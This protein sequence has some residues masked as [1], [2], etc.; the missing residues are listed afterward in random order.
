MS[1]DGVLGGPGDDR[2]T[3]GHPTSPILNVDPGQPESFST[4]RE[5]PRRVHAR[6]LPGHPAYEQGARSSSHGMADPDL[7]RRQLLQD[8]EQ[9]PASAVQPMPPPAPPPYYGPPPPGYPPQANGFATPPVNY[10]PPP[11]QALYP[12]PG[13][14]Q[15]R[16]VVLAHRQADYYQGQAQAPRP[17]DQ[18]LTFRLSEG[19]LDVY[20]HRVVRS[21]PLLWLIYDARLPGQRFLP[22]P[23]RGGE[24]R[25]FAAYVYGAERG[26]LLRATHCRLR[27][28]QYDCV[29]LEILREEASAQERER[30]HFEDQTPALPEE[31]YGGEAGGDPRG[32]D[33]AGAAGVPDFGLDG[34]P[35]EVGPG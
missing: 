32:P 26:F 16:D 34:H 7:L 12:Q 11:E 23:P 19:P 9:A 22:A 31:D 33:A 27:L 24:A 35:G 17:P 4:R 28:D 15:Q 6:N 21:G 30:N 20:C 29:G 3:I 5:V 1:Q 8:L 13:Y 14:Q 10:P 2:A 18:R 25:P